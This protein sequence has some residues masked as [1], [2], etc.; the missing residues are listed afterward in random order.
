MLPV[1]DTTG[2]RKDGALVAWHQSR[3][4]E[5]QLLFSYGCDKCWEEKRRGRES[6]LA[7]RSGRPLICLH[8]GQRLG[9]DLGRTQGTL[10]RV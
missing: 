2:S 7:A 10:G 1:G 9:V 6:P 8:S 3:Q 5:G 4:V